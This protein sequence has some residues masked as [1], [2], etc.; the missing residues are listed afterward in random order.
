MN[1][2]A[3]NQGKPRVSVLLPVYNGFPYLPKTIDSV[4]AQSFPHWIMYAINDGSSDESAAYLDGLA[5]PRIVVVHNQNQGL[6]NTLNEGLRLCDTEYIARL[7][8]D[9]E[10][11]PD[12]FEKQVEF[13]DAH[14]DVGMLGSQ[15]CRMGTARS[16]SGSHLPESH[17]EI[18]KALID[19]QHAICH[20]S[21]MCRKEAFDQ[22]GDYKSMVGEDWDM[23]LRFGEKW[24]LANHPDRLLKY[25]F[26][27]G[28][29]NGTRMGIMRQRIRYHCE[30]H[31]LRVA[32]K[33]E[34]SFEE[35]VS[36]EE[37]LGFVH[38]MLQRSEDFSRAR[39]HSAMADLL[40]DNRLRGYA[41]MGMAAV[42]APQL[43]IMRI[44]R[45][46]RSIA[47]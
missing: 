29:I 8:A 26:H 12:R 44:G 34:I 27:G 2:D 39:Y 41:R 7:D 23:Y 19:G 1:D 33:P 17:D 3:M 16:D 47:S 11:M 37:Q 15:I 5:D 18:M 9:D 21:V 32:G 31:R 35:F 42:C 25:R 6:S 36:G 28:S 13:M 46:L 45:K 24:K 10:C 38:K 20:P 4:L 40:G 22:V 30:C 14:P 43:T